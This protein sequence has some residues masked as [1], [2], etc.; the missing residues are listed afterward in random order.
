[1]KN[2]NILVL[3]IS[4]IFVTPVISQNVIKLGIVGLDTSH[5]PAF[6][7]LLN[8]ENSEKQYKDFKIVAAYPYGSKTIES[9]YKRIPGYVEEAKKYGVKI[10]SS[11]EEMLKLVDCVF[12]E[13]NDGNCHLEQ[14][15]QIFKAGKPTFIDKPVAANLA[16]TIAI[17]ELAKK[18]NIPIFSSSSL[19]YAAGNQAI[20][21]GKYG[22]VLGAD[23]YSPDAYEPSHVDFTWYGIHGVEILYTIMGTGCIQV[24]RATTKDFTVTTG[25]WEDGR[26]GTFRGIRGH[27]YYGGSVYCDSKVIQADG[28]PGYKSLLDQVLKFFRTKETPIDSNETIEIYTFIEAATQSKILNGAPVPMKAVLEKGKI[29]AARIL[30]NLKE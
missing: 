4:L 30:R 10:T 6:I 15:L 25:I 27:N 22:K 24:S 26:I 20:R 17:F 21:E 8:D 7:K 28:F 1:M 14:A 23:C 9:S 3:I 29:E 2:K 13:T 16:E 12:L 5:A 11:I 19:R 18:Y